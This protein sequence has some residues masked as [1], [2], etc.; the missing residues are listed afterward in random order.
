M[1][2]HAQF[3]VL[4]S[5][6]N[7]AVLSGR[8]KGLVY[9]ITRD[10]VEVKSW[11]AATSLRNR[12]HALP[13]LPRHTHLFIGHRQAVIV[14]EDVKPLGK[15]HGLDPGSLTYL[16]VGSRLGNKS[17][18]HGSR[19]AEYAARRHLS[20]GLS[21]PLR[22]VGRALRALYGM[23]ARPSDLR[24]D[25]FG[26]T[27]RGLVLHDP[28]RSPIET[29]V[30]K[31]KGQHDACPQV[32]KLA[33]AVRAALNSDPYYRDCRVVSQDG[34]RRV[35]R[36]HGW[37]DAEIDDTAGFH[38]QDN[39]IYLLRG[40]EWSLLHELV[41]AAGVVDKDLASWVTEGIT[42]AAA[43]DIAKSKGMQHRATYPQYV[44]I[45]RQQLAPALG[46]TPM[47]VAEVV[48]ARPSKAGRDLASRLALRS[49]VSARSW[50]KAIGPGATSPEAFLRLM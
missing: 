48:A 49:D 36:T 33:G 5:G 18:L 16:Q 27:N 22:P 17:S 20:F 1:P 25:N 4:G 41:H 19:R 15:T 8:E 46:L 26:W 50:Y 40:N 44:K 9:K 34:M 32:K 14:R 42:E 30:A 12:G 24:P 2:R 39:K 35:M 45:V 11:L 29:T 28:G 13:G 37:R 31:A 43:E 7:G 21:G 38:T 47:Q 10:P 23:G 6:N 3:T